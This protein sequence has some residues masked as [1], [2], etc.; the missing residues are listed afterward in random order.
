MSPK[1]GLIIGIALIALAGF[2][3]AVVMPILR[4]KANVE[5]LK[6]KGILK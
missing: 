1:T 5:T 6:N 3:L 4:R 2:L